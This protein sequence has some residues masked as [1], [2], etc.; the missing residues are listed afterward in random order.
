MRK[1]YES[2]PAYQEWIGR[3]KNWKNERDKIPN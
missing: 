1:K 2:N 3:S